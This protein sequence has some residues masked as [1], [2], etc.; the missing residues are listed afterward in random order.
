M[1]LKYLSSPPPHLNVNIESDIRCT[2]DGL[3]THPTNCN[4]YINCAVGHA[5]ITRCADGTYFN[6]HTQTCTYDHSICNTPRFR[7]RYDRTS[8]DSSGK[9]AYTES[10]RNSNSKVT[11]ISERRVNE[12]RETG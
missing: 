10:W 11:G 5:Y 4:Y 7:E 3:S 9:A 1:V 2:K 12:Y 8:Q 6:P